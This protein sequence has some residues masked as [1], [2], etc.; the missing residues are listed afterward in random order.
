MMRIVVA[1]FGL[2]VLG[3]CAAEAPLKEEPAFYLSMAHGGAK[4]DPAV[5]ASMIS[6]A[7]QKS[8]GETARRIISTILA[9]ANLPKV[10]PRGKK[11]VRRLA[12]DKKTVNGMPHFVLPTEIGKVEI[13]SDVPERAV[14]QAV[15]E[16]RYLSLAG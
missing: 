6:A 11:I 1:G 9:Y 3:G 14:V 16:L 13:V 4:V 8:D 15:D 5:A 2:L 10:E 12:V 7:M